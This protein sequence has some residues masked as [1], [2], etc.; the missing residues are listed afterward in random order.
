[1]PNNTPTSRQ[2]LESLEKLEQEA[3]PGTFGAGHFGSWR[4]FAKHYLK[5]A[6]IRNPIIL[7]SD[8]R[9]KSHGKYAIC[10]IFMGAEPEDA[11]NATLL[12]NLRNDALPALRQSVEECERLDKFAKAFALNIVSHTPTV[13]DRCGHGYGT[14]DPDCI[15]L[16][17]KQ[18]L[19]P[20]TPSED[21][22]KEGR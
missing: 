19:A 8:V 9:L 18:F 2:V 7:W 13:C 11:A 17:A 10:A 4:T 14:H 1:M 20:T 3:T 22:L 21:T 5:L 16:A 6:R 15:V 12:F